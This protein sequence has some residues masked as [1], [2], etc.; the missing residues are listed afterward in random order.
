ML[1]FLFLLLRLVPRGKSD[2]KC[3]VVKFGVSREE[4]DSSVGMLLDG[5]VYFPC[6]LGDTSWGA[7]YDTCAT[8]PAKMEGEVRQRQLRFLLGVIRF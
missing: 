3:V 5:N 8:T 4:V 7:L 1:N 6:V 2:R